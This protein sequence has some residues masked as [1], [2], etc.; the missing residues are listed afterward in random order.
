MSTAGT[1]ASTPAY[2]TATPSSVPKA[3]LQVPPTHVSERGW[4]GW[5]RGSS[6]PWGSRRASEGWGPGLCRPAH[7]PPARPLQAPEALLALL[8]GQASFRQ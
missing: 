6:S 4:V 5:E 2:P 7:R 1:P 8:L 3:T